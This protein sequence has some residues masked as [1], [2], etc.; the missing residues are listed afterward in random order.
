MLDFLENHDIPIKDCRGQS[1]DNSSSMSGKYAGLSAKIKEKCEF[2]TFV[3]C[4]GHFLNM[5]D[6]HAAGCVS[7]AIS[8]FQMVQKLYNFFSSSTHP[9]NTLI[10]HS[11]SKKVLKCLSQT[12]WPARADA[13]SALHEGHKQIIE[14]LMS[15]AEDAEQPRET[16][17]KPLGL[18]RKMGNPEFIILTEI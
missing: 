4:A 9:W 17:H 13:V 14:A 18:S 2:A 15:I 1:Y 5:V 10:E 11:G 3:P 8:Y 6:A 7:E 16:R 12:R